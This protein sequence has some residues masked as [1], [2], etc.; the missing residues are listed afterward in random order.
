MYL[1]VYITQTTEL[2]CMYLSVSALL[3]VAAAGVFFMAV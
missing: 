3:A 2:I 1:L